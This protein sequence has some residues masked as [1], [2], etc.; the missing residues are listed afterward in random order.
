MHTCNR[1]S[2]TVQSL[3]GGMQ[4][5]DLMRYTKN[6]DSWTVKTDTLKY[7]CELGLATEPNHPADSITRPT[8]TCPFCAELIQA[9]AIKCRYCH[10][11]LDRSPD[12][13]YGPQVKRA[14][15][16]VGSVILMILFL[17]PFALPVIW[18]KTRFNP[19]T[20]VIITLIILGVTVLCLFLLVDAYQRVLDQIDVLGL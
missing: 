15:L 7:D 9:E 2:T 8:K 5:R 12:S 20:K 16:G 19:L 14:G 3:S 6:A 1:W 10:E 4:N 18:L 11:F 17:G 13:V